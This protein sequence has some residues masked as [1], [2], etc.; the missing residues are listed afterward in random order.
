VQHSGTAVGEGVD[1]GSSSHKYRTGSVRDQMCTV[2]EYKYSWSTP[3]FY[4][5][6]LST[7]LV[8]QWRSCSVL[9]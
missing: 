6:E 7:V 9:R 3:V 1:C 4:V 8:D 5:M 2:L